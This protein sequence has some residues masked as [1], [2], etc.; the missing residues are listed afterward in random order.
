[1]VSEQWL[2]LFRWNVFSNLFERWSDA[3]AFRVTTSG[4]PGL[5]DLGYN[6]YYMYRPYML[7]LCILRVYEGPWRIN[8]SHKLIDATNLGLHSTPQPIYKRLLSSCM[9]MV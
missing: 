2:A 8:L 9:F 4:W 7:C 5:F 1:M 3:P 6:Y